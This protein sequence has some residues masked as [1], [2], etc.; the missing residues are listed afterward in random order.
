MQDHRIWVGWREWVALPELGI[1][2]LKAKIDTGARTSALHTFA[3]E[4]FERHDEQWVRF[5]VH[6]K[7][8]S[9]KEQLWCESKVV[10]R[11]LVSDSGGKREKRWVIETNLELNG[12]AWPIEVTLTARD[13]M[14]FRMLLGR[15][16]M[17]G[18]VLIDPQASYLAKGLAGE[19]SPP[20]DC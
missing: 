8:R 4:A 11:R 9:V 6:L 13:T 1:E 10:D 14:R 15:S 17:A 7:Q 3:I 18:R 5:G 19:N 2:R 16:A 12:A 20:E